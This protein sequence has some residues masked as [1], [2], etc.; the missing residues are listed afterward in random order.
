M[1][2]GP[3]RLFIGKQAYDVEKREENKRESLEWSWDGSGGL[4]V[5]TRFCGIAFVSYRMVKPTETGFQVLCPIHRLVGLG[6]YFGLWI[7]YYSV[8]TEE[9]CRGT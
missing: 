1:L 5:S 7:E 9:V 3:N 4:G 2:C 6:V 8:C